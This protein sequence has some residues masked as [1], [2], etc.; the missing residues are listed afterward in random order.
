MKTSTKAPQSSAKF[1]LFFRVSSRFFVDGFLRNLIPER[2]GT[3]FAFL[4]LAA[5]RKERE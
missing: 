3:L 4:A 1:F 2:M 5:L